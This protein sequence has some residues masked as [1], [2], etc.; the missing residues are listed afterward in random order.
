MP[1]IRTKGGQLLTT[2]YL[3][4]VMQGGFPV[5]EHNQITLYRGVLV[6]FDEDVDTRVL[7]WLDEQPCE[8]VDTLFMVQEHEGSLTLL[9]KKAM[10]AHLKEGD[11]VDVDGDVW[12]VFVSK[13]VL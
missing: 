12:S 4:S 9:W 6:V 3:S 10:P 2:V 13:L 7:T 5:G 8:V 11:S 1:K